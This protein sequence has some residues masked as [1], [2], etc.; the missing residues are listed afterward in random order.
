M[1]Q[2]AKKFV[3]RYKVV[4]LLLLCIMVFGL[5]LFRQQ[6]PSGN[7]YNTPTKVIMAQAVVVEQGAQV[8]WLESQHGGHQIATYIIERSRDGHNFEQVARIENIFLSYLD[9]D[10]QT[11]DLYRVSAEDTSGSRSPSSDYLA[12]APAKP[13]SVVI[14][15]LDTTHVL[16]ATTSLEQAESPAQKAAALHNLISQSFTNID[17]TVSIK[18]HVTVQNL[19]SELQSYQRQALS[20]W[21]KLA[22]DQKLNLAQAC[23]EHDSAFRANIY[24]MPEEYQFDTTIARASCDALQKG[25]I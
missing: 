6:P 8:T 20:L 23:T 4:A 15:S 21:P 2:M 14:A 24:A 9:A 19:L 3:R 17:K 7:S 5:L 1:R 12:A 25:V 13:G 18:D 11:N 22:S 10:G 16:G